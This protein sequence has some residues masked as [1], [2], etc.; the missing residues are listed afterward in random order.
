MDYFK[1]FMPLS[2]DCWL[3]EIL[4]GS[5]APAATA[6]ALADAIDTDKWKT[7]DYFVFALTGS[8]D[9][10]EQ[11]L[12]PQIE[13]MKV[14]PP[15]LF[16]DNFKKGNV[17]YSILEGGKHESSTFAPHYLYTALPEFFGR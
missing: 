15:F 7:N 10:A 13:A 14:Q 16:D 3:T 11:S 6:K 1:Y 17:Y 5:K 2:G 9:M 12:T 4:G 8:E